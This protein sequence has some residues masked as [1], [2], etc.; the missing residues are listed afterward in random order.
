[1]GDIFTKIGGLN[2]PLQ[3]KP[4]VLSKKRNLKNVFKGPVESWRK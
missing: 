4:L 1:L 3:K 2:S